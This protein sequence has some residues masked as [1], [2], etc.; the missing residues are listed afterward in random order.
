MNEK[1]QYVVD[2]LD[3][4]SQLFD[5][6]LILSVMDRD[7]V[8]QGFSLPKEIPPQVEVGSVLIGSVPCQPVSER[9]VSMVSLQ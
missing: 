8:V 4:I 6:E 1:L 5:K 3:M 2:N 9:A 7:K